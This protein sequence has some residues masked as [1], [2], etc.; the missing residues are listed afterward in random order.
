M[1]EDSIEEEEEE[2]SER[3]R[4]R[5]V[6]DGKEKL[7]TSLLSPLK[8]GTNVE[9]ATTASLL[10][11]LNDPP[12]TSVKE[13][14][15]EVRIPTTTITSCETPSNSGTTPTTERTTLEIDA[16]TLEITTTSPVPNPTS[17]ASLF[18]RL[19]IDTVPS[20]PQLPIISNFSTT[21]VSQLPPP[22][23]THPLPSPRLSS[24]RSLE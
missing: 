6:L 24:N 7:E 12:A 18:L 21:K 11:L 15:E 16:S 1:D 8:E 19:E 13:K 14:E 5:E 4:G 17:K 9:E 22:R 3:G 20:L 2:E 23:P 10:L